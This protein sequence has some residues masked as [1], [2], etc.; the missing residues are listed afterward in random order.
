MCDVY[1]LFF[2]RKKLPK[3]NKE[4]ALKLMEEGDAD[5]AMASR[6]KKAN[7]GDCIIRVFLSSLVLFSLA[8]RDVVVPPLFK[9]QALPS[10][11]ED[12]R[13]KVMFENPEYQVD[14]QSEEFRLLNPIVSKVSQKRKKKL[15]LLVQQA[16]AS[17]QVALLC[18]TAPNWDIL[19]F[20]AL[21]IF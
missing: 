14:E 9:P 10:I 1:I 8:P 18:F 16:A 5:A 12:D 19:C 3:V 13:F 6:K 17:E 2:L 4:L 15:R 21:Q 7:V 11:L 20:N